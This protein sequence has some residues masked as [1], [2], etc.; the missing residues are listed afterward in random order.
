MTALDQQMT[1][2]EGKLAR[3][4]AEGERGRGGD[5]TR[6]EVI[7]MVRDGRE[8]PERGDTIIEPLLKTEVYLFSDA[9]VQSMVEEVQR[10][11]GQVRELGLQ[12]RE[13]GDRVRRVQGETNDNTERFG[14][15][16]A[17]AVSRVETV[18]ISR[19]I[20]PF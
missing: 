20:L 17:E 18:R 12:V 5:I 11:M 19:I 1:V 4:I 16:L 10:V 8:N 14:V 9:Q 2:M 6:E 13:T 15:E 3:S 7:R